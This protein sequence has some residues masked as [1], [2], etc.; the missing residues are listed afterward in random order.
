[1]ATISECRYRW[2]RV[3]ATRHQALEKNRFRGFLLPELKP[4]MSFVEAAGGKSQRKT[5]GI[6]CD[7]MTQL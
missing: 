6:G 7:V 5:G 4:E 1:M 2:L 3:P